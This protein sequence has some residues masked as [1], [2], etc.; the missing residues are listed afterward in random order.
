MMNR[1]SVFLVL[2]V[3]GIYVQHIRRS[4]RKFDACLVIGIAARDP[5]YDRARRDGER[6]NADIIA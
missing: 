1:M 2:E 4:Y 6:E 5:K 3:Y